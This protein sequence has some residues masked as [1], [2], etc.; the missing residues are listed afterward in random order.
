VPADSYPDGSNP[1][2]VYNMAGKVWEWVGDW[3]DEEYY[4]RSPAENSP[5]S[6]DGLVNVITSGA[7]P[8][9]Y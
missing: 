8:K 2:G 3:Y 7:D 5:G 6:D 4:P 1:Y 9:E